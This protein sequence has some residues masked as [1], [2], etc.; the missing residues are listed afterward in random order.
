[1]LTLERAHGKRGPRPLNRPLCVALPLAPGS[2]AVSDRAGVRSRPVAAAVQGGTGPGQRGR[3]RN[4]SH[5]LLEGPQVHVGRVIA[6]GSRTWHEV[7]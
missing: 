3:E 4:H 2:R 5:R 1:M 6:G 7:T